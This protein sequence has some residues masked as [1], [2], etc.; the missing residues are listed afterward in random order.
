MGDDSRK[1]E[2]PLIEFLLHVFEQVD[3]QVVVDVHVVDLHCFFE[4]SHLSPH[5]PGGSFGSTGSMGLPSGHGFLYAYSQGTLV[6]RCLV[7]PLISSR[8]PSFTVN[9]VISAALVV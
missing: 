2:T 4:Q 9:W 6:Y 1:F 8:V 3:V 7:F 5:F